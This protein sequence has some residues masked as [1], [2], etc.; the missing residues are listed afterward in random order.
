ME[1]SPPTDLSNINSLPQ[2]T[3]GKIALDLSYK[4]I[5][6]LCETSRKFKNIC[7]DKY[8]WRDYMEKNYLKN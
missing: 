2:D 7:N 6:K 5:S 8:F 4:D 3:I 1:I